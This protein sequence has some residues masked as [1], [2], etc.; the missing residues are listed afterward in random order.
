MPMTDNSDSTVIDRVSEKT[1]LPPR[2]NIVFHNDDYTPM[3]FVIF[4][5]IGVFSMTEEKANEIMM[6][7]HKQG[8]AIAGTYSLDIAQ[9]RQMQVDSYSKHFQ[10]P[11]QTTL[12]PT[13]P[14]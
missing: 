9:T 10:H 6:T 14:E 3:D 13:E 5:L 12:E 11:L 1:K 2:W 4:V 8:K 7:V